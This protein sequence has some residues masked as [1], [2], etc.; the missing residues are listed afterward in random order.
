MTYPDNCLRG[1]WNEQHVG[2]DG[3]VDTSVFYFTDACVRPT[4]DFEQS[5]NWEDDDKAIPFTLSQKKEDG[6]P[7]FKGGV[8]VIARSELDRLSKLPTLDQA[9]SYDRQPLP[10]NSYHGN[11]VLAAGVSKQ[12]RKYLA[13]A[14]ALHVC[15]I[16]RQPHI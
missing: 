14:I 4:G 5:V 16:V 15:R 3:L 7:Q 12:R 11:L 13:A 1:I 6:T 8:A 10:E 2:K 9:L